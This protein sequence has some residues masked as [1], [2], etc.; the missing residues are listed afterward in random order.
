MRISTHLHIKGLAPATILAL[1]QRLCMGN[2]EMV[3]CH[4]GM[5]GENI[6]YISIL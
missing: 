6:T 3:Y 4:D 5:Y 1:K 2:S